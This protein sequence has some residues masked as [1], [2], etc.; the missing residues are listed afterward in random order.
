MPLRAIRDAWLAHNNLGKELQSEGLFREASSQFA[1]AVRLRP[2]SPE[3]HANW[4][5]ALDSQGLGDA[6]RREF[7]LCHPG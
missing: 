6:A 4:G 3:A 7:A 5:N 1:E 2:D